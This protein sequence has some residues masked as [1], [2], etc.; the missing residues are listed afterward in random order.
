MILKLSLILLLLLF[1]EQLCILS[2]EAM[3]GGEKKIFIFANIQ[4]VNNVQ[5]L[6]FCCGCSL[7]LASLVS[8]LPVEIVHQHFSLQ[9]C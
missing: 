3:I 6:L 4:V 9:C 1:F 7:V 8:H 5:Y 2:V